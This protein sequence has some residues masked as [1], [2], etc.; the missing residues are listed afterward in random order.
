MATLGVN[1]PTLVDVAKRLNPDGTIAT[2]AEILSEVNEVLQDFP[3]LEA[4]L[5]T[6]HRE[7]IR[8]GLPD[9]YWRRFNKGVPQSKSRT[10]QITDTI[11]M[12]EARAMVD[13]ELADLNGNSAQWRL[14]EDKGHLE[15]MSQKLA[16][17]IFYGNEL[18]NPDEFTGL[19]ARY[20]SKSAENG[21]NIVDAGGTTGKLTS[22]W[23]VCWDTDTVNMRYPKGMADGAGITSNDLGVQQVN[24]SDGNRYEA[25]ET[26]Y[27]AKLGMSVKDWRYVVRI[28][29]VPVALLEDDAATYDLWNLIIKAMHKLP[30]LTKG[31]CYFYM[32]RTVAQYLDLQSFNKKNVQL[33]RTEINGRMIPDFRG[34]PFRTVDK[35]LNTEDRIQ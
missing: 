33:N 2:P 21:V 25:L 29:N 14:S 24:D 11:G 4:N 26:K 6:G 16:Q 22:I 17:T 7:T 20:S 19:A 18:T 32:N 1:W 15:S 35:L 8:T 5:P 3:V 30:M 23:L 9:V 34:I 13:K 31:K 28:A 12:M 10:Q 27:M